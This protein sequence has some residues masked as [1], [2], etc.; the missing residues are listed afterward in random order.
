[1]AEIRRFVTETGS[2]KI[3][4]LLFSFIV[5]IHRFPSMRKEGK[6]WIVLDFGSFIEIYNSNTVTIPQLWYVNTMIGVFY[7]PQNSMNFAY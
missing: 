6:W 3:E 4:L 2:F 5:S 7:I 1:M